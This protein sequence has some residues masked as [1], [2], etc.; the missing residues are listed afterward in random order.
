MKKQFLIALFI[1]T[2]FLCFSQV[3]EKLPIIVKDKNGIIESIEFPDSIISSKI[4]SSADIFFK[5]Y[6]K[7][8]VKDEF[9]KEST[10]MK[11]KEFIHEHFDQYYKGIKVDGAGYS[12]HYRNGKMFF[13]NGNYVK[14]DELNTDPAISPEKAKECFAQ[15]KN[16]PKDSITDFIAELMVKKY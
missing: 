12:F 9:R 5:D 10:K 11:K 4:P 2:P 1:A 16:I 15:F 3:K 6:L 7:I 14:I 13:A 8:S